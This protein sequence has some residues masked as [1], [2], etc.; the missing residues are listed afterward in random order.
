M[1]K[2]EAKEIVESSIEDLNDRLEKR[3]HLYLSKRKDWP[4]FKEFFYRRNIVVHNYGV[5]NS[6]YIKKTKFKGEK[7]YWLEIDNTYINEAFKIFESYAN[8][9]A[10]FFSKKYGHQNKRERNNK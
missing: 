5:P 2:R 10:D 6:T 3:F 1:S 9:I 8:E 7:N 4:K